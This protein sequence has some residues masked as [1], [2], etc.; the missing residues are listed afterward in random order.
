MNLLWH[1]E[2]HGYKTKTHHKKSAIVNTRSEDE[3]KQR[4]VFN[5]RNMDVN[6]F[7]ENCKN[8]YNF[9]S[10][11]KLNRKQNAIAQLCV[12]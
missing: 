5:S 10:I 1:Y 2:W 6:A 3:R 7:C 12:V 4:T 8:M 11:A 9:K